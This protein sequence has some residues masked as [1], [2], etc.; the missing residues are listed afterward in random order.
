MLKQN[1]LFGVGMDRY[2]AYFK[3]FREVGYPLN[4]GF[5]ITSSNAHNTFIQLFATGGVFLGASYLI[6]NGYILKRAIFG[7]KNLT[8][9]NQI[10][11]AGVFSAWVAFH[12]QSLVSID[13]IG[14]SI[15]GWVLGG[16]IVGLSISA[17][18]SIVEDRK[19]FISKRND[20]NLTRVMFSTTATVIPIVLIVLLY[21]GEVNTYKASV[22]YSLQDQASVEA[23]KDLQMK[24]VNT[25]LIEYSYAL[26]CGF[27]LV[28]AELTE[29]G[30]NVF[31]RIHLADPRNL[32]A[33][34][35]LVLTYEAYN[36]IPE[37]IIYRKKMA[38]LDPWNAVNYLALAKDYKSQGD[39]VNS[40]MMIDKILT[41]ATGIEGGPIAEQAKK[42]LAQ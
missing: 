41:F 7:L 42:E 33:I 10:L 30:I 23:F 4:Y 31:K 11:L 2:G 13:N 16:S 15:W 24:A 35:S 29:D 18:P 6:L 25:P 38:S 40:K 27:S 32:D 14:I 1:P 3:Q 21:R 20:I 26:G 34:N 8:G 12:A 39:I 22:N 36:R 5:D 19:P 9:N 28:R 37:A 17:S